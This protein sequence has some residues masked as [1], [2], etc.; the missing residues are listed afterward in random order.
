[1]R[2]HIPKVL[3]VLV[4]ALPT[5]VFSQSKTITI[6]AEN[7]TLQDV[8]T[9]IRTQTGF[10]FILND[11]IISPTTKVNLNVDNVSLDFTL[12]QLFKGLDASYTIKSKT[13]VVIPKQTNSESERIIISG[14]IFDAKTNIPVPFA[15]LTIGD[16]YFGV[17]SNMDGSFR[18]PVSRNDT[19]IFLKIRCIGYNQ[20]I[21]KVSVSEFYSTQAYYI[22]PTSYN[23]DEVVVEESVRKKSAAEIVHLAVSHIE[24][25]Y[26]NHPFLLKGYYRDYLKVNEHYENLYE[27]AV[28][29]EDMG[30]S[31]NDREQT[32]IGLIY[33]AMNRTFPIDSTKIINYGENKGIPYGIIQFNGTNEF[34]F[35]RFHNPIRNF[36]YRSFDFIRYIQS[37]FLENHTFTLEGVEYID[38]V[39][40]YH[41]AFSYYNPKSNEYTTGSITPIKGGKPVF[42]EYKAKGDIYIQSSN[43]KIHKLNYQV[44]YDKTKL[45]DL[46]LEYRDKQGV[47]YLNYLSFNNLVEYSDFSSSESFYLNNIWIDKKKEFIKLNFNCKVDSLS[48]TNHKNYKLD[49]DGNRLKVTK[50]TVTDTCVVLKIK[51]FNRMLGY[52]D[53]QYSDRFNVKL[54]RIKNNSGIKIN[55]IITARAYQ[56]REFFVNDASADFQPIPRE[57]CLDP[58]K[59]MI[60]FKNIDETKPDTINFNSPLLH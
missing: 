38:S 44:F 49:F 45:W 10:D 2:I 24:S 58:K 48:A 31:T 57:R 47:L 22:T 28:E 25:N 46:N 14:R 60:Y 3:I 12:N 35:L 19:S 53:Q 1:M 20:L 39:P 21:S 5:Q 26:P 59:S 7:I 50:V 55:S 54:N 52:F 37:D 41:I 33:G 30:F 56:Y 36:E 18:L 43:Y 32:K 17:I 42:N 27:A 34:N 23:I 8:F 9:T 15:T 29:V 16:G 6:Q 40:C 51:D 11:E 13:I 4:F